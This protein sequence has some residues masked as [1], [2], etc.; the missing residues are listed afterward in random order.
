MAPWCILQVVVHS[1][2]GSGVQLCHGSFPGYGRAHAPLWMQPPA[3]LLGDPTAQKN[4]WG[5]C[6]GVCYLTSVIFS[7]LHMRH[8]LTVMSYDEQISEWSHTGYEN[9]RVH[10]LLQAYQQSDSNCE[11][12]N[13]SSP[14]SKMQIPLNIFGILN[15]WKSLSSSG[16]PI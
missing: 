3:H 1:G 13:V 14:A 4:G 16:W 11:R 8:W 5:A 9:T 10:C 6:S 12:T 7:V 2:N 15:Q